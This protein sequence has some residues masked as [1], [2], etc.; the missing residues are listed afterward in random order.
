LPK[1]EKDSQ[2]ATCAGFPSLAKKQRA[3]VCDPG[4][5]EAIRRRFHL[6]PFAVTIPEADREMDLQAQPKGRSA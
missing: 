1:R 5:D 4:V 6:I 2:F 3:S